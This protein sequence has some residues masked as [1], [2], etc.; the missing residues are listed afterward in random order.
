MGD[1]V[2]GEILVFELLSTA[3]PA[4]GKIEEMVD[5]CNYHYSTRM[6]FL[7]DKRVYNLSSFRSNIMQVSYPDMMLLELLF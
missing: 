7:H 1:G 2:F 5:L 3:C 4:P 6:E